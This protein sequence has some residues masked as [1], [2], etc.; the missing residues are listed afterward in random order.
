MSAR[1][2]PNAVF[3]GGRD[4]GG[5]ELLKGKLQEGET[6]I[7]VCKKNVCKLPVRSV[8]EALGQVGE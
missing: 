5:L 3:L 6:F 7:Y 1:Y 8:E 2:L 4:E